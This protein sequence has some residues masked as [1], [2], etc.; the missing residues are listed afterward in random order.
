VLAFLKNIK[1][2]FS[3]MKSKF[4]LTDIGLF[5][6]YNLDS[7][8]VEEFDSKFYKNVNS[9]KILDTNAKIVISSY[10]ESTYTA[11]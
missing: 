2:I 7:Y 4:I 6:N 8:Y 9:L 1:R 5:S 11:L 10:K 3:K